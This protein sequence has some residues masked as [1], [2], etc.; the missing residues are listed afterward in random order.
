MVIATLDDK[1]DAT[2]EFDT[3]AAWDGLT[4]GEELEEA[5]EGA[6]VVVM[7]SLAS[8]L[9]SEGSPGST[10]AA[11]VRAIR[12]VAIMTRHEKKAESCRRPA[13]ASPVAIA[14]QAV[15]RHVYRIADNG[16]PS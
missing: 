1:G 5:V 7:G 4:M 6:E 16:I 2:Y 15:E 11:T 9:G 12:N 14:Q 13:T 8:R 3:P 10:S